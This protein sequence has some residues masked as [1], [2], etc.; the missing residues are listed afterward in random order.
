MLDNSV[1]LGFQQTYQYFGGIEQIAP[2]L[3]F[4]NFV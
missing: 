1:N 2:P 4:R 3:P